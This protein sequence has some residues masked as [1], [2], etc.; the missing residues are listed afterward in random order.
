[1]ISGRIQA[2]TLMDL[3]WQFREETNS[4]VWIT[5][6]K[7]LQW[8]LGC[9]LN[10]DFYSD[11]IE[12]LRKFFS[13]IK[14]KIGFE[15]KPD[16]SNKIYKFLFFVIRLIKYYLIFRQ[17]GKTI[18]RRYSSYVGENRRLRIQSVRSRSVYK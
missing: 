15:I 9:F 16:E 5:L 6:I 17:S 18:K 4:Y 7:N 14:L 13:T 8:L 1:V 3:I 12:F 10:S 2:A 11:F